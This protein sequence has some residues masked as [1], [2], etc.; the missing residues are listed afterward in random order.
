MITL[1][2]KE[3]PRAVRV[4]VNA[5]AVNVHLVDGRVIIMPLKYNQISPDGLFGW[6]RVSRFGFRVVFGVKWTP[7]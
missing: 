6:F 7:F 1:T 4:D 2:I 3:A 5:P